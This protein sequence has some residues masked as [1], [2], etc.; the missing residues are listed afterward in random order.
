MMPPTMA[1][2]S[3]T[4]NPAQPAN[5]FRSQWKHPGD[6][7]TILLIIGGDVVARALAQLTGSPFTPVAFSFG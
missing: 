4:F 3:R 2:N 5:T 6:V 1:L 7:F